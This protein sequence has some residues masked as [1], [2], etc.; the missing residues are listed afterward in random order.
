MKK[1]IVLLSLAIMG[2][3]TF[4]NAQER[5]DINQAKKYAQLTRQNPELL[6]IAPLQFEADLTRPVALTNEDFGGL[7]IPRVKLSEGSESDVGAQPVGIGELWLYNLTVE[8]NGWPV[9]EHEL[10]VVT[11]DTDEGKV[12]VPRYILGVSNPAEGKPVL[13]VYGKTKKP[14]LTVPLTRIQSSQ[15]NPLDMTATKDGKVTVSILGQYQ[16]HFYVSELFL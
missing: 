14:L 13:M 8:K 16:G 7:L 9:Y 3:V 5:L 10:N 6:K 11:L 12:K 1:S 4:T 15:A 2:T